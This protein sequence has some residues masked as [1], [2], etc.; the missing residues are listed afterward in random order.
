VRTRRLSDNEASIAPIRKVPAQQ[1]DPSS[2]EEWKERGNLHFKKGEWA[3]AKNAYTRQ[4]PSNMH[5]CTASVPI[6]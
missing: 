2:A 4:A 3:A 6:S 1:A 5:L